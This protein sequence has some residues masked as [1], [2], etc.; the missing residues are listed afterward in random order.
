MILFDPISHQTASR[1]SSQIVKA[2][3]EGFLEPKAS[4]SEKGRAA[5]SISLSHS[6]VRMYGVW[7]A[8]RLAMV[9]VGTGENSTAP[10]PSAATVFGSFWCT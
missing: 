8:L 1:L 7:L 9:V 10:V 5:M 4:S 3:G 6:H 2:G